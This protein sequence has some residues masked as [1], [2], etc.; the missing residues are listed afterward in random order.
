MSS[1]KKYTDEEV[2][3]IVDDA[4]RKAEEKAAA[5]LGEERELTPDELESAAGG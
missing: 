5:G 2:K 4:L 3:A 1:E